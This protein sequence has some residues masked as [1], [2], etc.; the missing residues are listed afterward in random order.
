MTRFSKCFDGCF[1]PSHIAADD[2]RD[3]PNI[4]LSEGLKPRTV[5]DHLVCIRAVFQA[6]RAAGILNAN[7]AEDLRRDGV[8]LPTPDQITKIQKR[9]K[10]ARKRIKIRSAAHAEDLKDS[11]AELLEQT[12]IQISQP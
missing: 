1:F 9:L 11:V 2:L 12:D 4:L 5:D 7:P 3:Y 8:E 10:E 6:N